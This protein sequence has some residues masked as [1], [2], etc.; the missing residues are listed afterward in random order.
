[1]DLWSPVGARI[2]E[3]VK[4]DEEGQGRGTG[5]EGDVQGVV[6]RVRGGVG[7]GGRR[8]GVFEVVVDFE[9][10]IDGRFVVFCRLWHFLGMI[11]ARE[12]GEGARGGRMTAF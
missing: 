7:F 11:V 2:V 4:E 6:D 3:R 12:G 9:G 10:V 5:E 1:M 8:F